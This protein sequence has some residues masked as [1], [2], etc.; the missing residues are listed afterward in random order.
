M[1]PDPGIAATI[2]LGSEHLYAFVA[3]LHYPQ[4]CNATAETGVGGS[5]DPQAIACGR[6][7]PFATR[8]NLKLSA[9]FQHVETKRFCE[10][11]AE[12]KSTGI[13]PMLCIG[14]LERFQA[15]LHDALQEAGKLKAHAACGLK[16]ASLREWIEWQSRQPM[17]LSKATP[18]RRRPKRV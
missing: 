12:I 3:R 1:P 14:S 15:I 8:K 5:P 2:K 16:W 13:S 4:F 18:N 7:A 17:W 11:E 9:T 10:L 6:L